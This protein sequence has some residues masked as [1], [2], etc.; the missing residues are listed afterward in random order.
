[1]PI[2]EYQ[3]ELVTLTVLVHVVAG[4]ILV[5]CVGG[6][7]S[8]VQTNAASRH[9]VWVFVYVCLLLLPS[10]SFLTPLAQSTWLSITPNFQVNN[11]QGLLVP[12]SNSIP[13]L[14]ANDNG[15]QI[16]SSDASALSNSLNIGSISG[17]AQQNPSP[18]ISQVLGNSIATF[19]VVVSL[20]ITSGIA[21]RIALVVAAYS[22]LCTILST[23]RPVNSE[24]LELIHKL[25]IRS[26]LRKAPAILRSSIVRSPLTGGIMRHWIVLPDFLLL[27]EFNYELIEQV[28]IHELAHL[29]RADQYV[30][31]F[32]TLTEI[33]MFWNPA[34]MFVSK[35]IK[36]ERE[37][38]CD[39][40]VLKSQ[41]YCD[42]QYNKAYASNLLKIAKVMQTRAFTEFAVAG[43]SDRNGLK[44]RIKRLLDQNLDHSTNIHK[45]KVAQFPILALSVVLFSTPFWPY[46]KFANAVYTD[47]QSDF[48]V[49]DFFAIPEESQLEVKPAGIF[50]AD[51][52]QS[53]PVV[54]IDPIEPQTLPVDP[55]EVSLNETGNDKD[56]KSSN[57]ETVDANTIDNFASGPAIAPDIKDKATAMEPTQPPYSL[58]K[59]TDLN[60]VAAPMIN[61]DARNNAL[62]AVSNLDRLKGAENF[63]SVN[64]YSQGSTE[65]V[66]VVVDEKNKTNFSIQIPIE[67]IMSNL[68][69][70]RIA[71]TDINDLEP[72][73]VSLPYQVSIKPQITKSE[74]REL[75]KKATDDFVARFNELNLDD[76]FD[77]TCYNSAST[78][79]YIRRDVCEP[80]YLT[81][82]GKVDTPLADAAASSHISLLM[83]RTHFSVKSEYSLRPMQKIFEELIKSDQELDQI[84]YVVVEL[85]HRLRKS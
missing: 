23:A 39:D 43:V 13:Q 20:L 52:I 17:A 79:T 44:Q 51:S 24:L 66:S 61:D 12:E 34:I 71:K 32:Q 14:P 63:S 31:I 74:L 76:D 72:V 15:L 78:L 84:S 19:G 3:F 40:F 26:G 45:T 46:N 11:F 50:S 38:A 6:C 8:L 18:L 2:M 27:E 73:P 75:L 33:I 62:L 83:N 64:E 9:S 80:A 16:Q 37:L 25:S 5:Y 65:E 57:D 85:K 29:K 69:D 82:K 35:Q 10:V 59:N 4:V 22:K 67:D 48:Q 30:A 77:I 1:M 56:L 58:A 55:S 47:Q 60:N 42:F 41:G 70:S 53:L 21:I 81:N 28:L 68:S 54:A 7:L 49:Q 36:V